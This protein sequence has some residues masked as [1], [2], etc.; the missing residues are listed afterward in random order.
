M[1]TPRLLIAVGC[2]ALGALLSGCQIGGATVEEK[3]GYF[4]WVDEQGRVR[5][6][7]IAKPATKSESATSAPSD[8]ELTSENY[9]DAEEL[10]RKGYVRDGEGKPYFTWRDAEGRVRSTYYQPD[11]RTDEEKGRQTPP[12]EISQA[13][14]FR[15]SDAPGTTKPVA[16]HDPNALAVLG[17]ED[18]DDD[19]LKRFSRSCCQSLETRHHA[20][21]QEGREFAVHLAGDSPEHRFLSGVSP[22]QL[23]ALP[24]ARSR[25]EGFYR[26]RSYAHNG[27]VVPSVAFLDGNLRP[28][29]LVTD[30]VLDFEPENWH[31]RGYLEARIPVTGSAEERWMLLFTRAADLDN[32][33]VVET[34][35]GPRKIPHVRTGELGLTLVEAH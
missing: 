18:T 16:G 13:S 34:R 25:N 4:S 15:I 31:R 27:V 19:Y 24:Q 23:V 8:D 2:L 30:L 6:S 29:R 26:L 14:V 9:P 20:R 17:V 5:Y 28:V 10:R 1:A 3:E 11:T 7:P 12:A 33:T 35:Q 22:Y 21:W 32:Q